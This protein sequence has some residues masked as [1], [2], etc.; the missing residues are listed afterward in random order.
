MTSSIEL[1]EVGR[2]E[3]IE[4]RGVLERWTGRE[5]EESLKKVRAPLLVLV[6]V[7]SGEDFAF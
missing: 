1:E 7:S 3:K 4:N 2:G 5:E 6:E